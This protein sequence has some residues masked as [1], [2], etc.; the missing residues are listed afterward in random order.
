MSKRPLRIVIVIFC[1]SSSGSLEMERCEHVVDRLESLNLFFLCIHTVTRVP[2]MCSA[3]WGPSGH[4]SYQPLTS[5]KLI[6]RSIASDANK[7]SL[8]SP[9]PIMIGTYSTPRP[10]RQKV[11]H[12][13]SSPL[14]TSRKTCFRIRWSEMAELSAHGVP[15]R[16]EALAPRVRIPHRGRWP[17]SCHVTRSNGAWARRWPSPPSSSTLMFLSL[18][19]QKVATALS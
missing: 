18:L 3:S 9:E 4:C 8:K 7:I 1:D 12:T 5:V 11:R 16:R 19:H 6:R 14:S 2:E 15:V 13:E 10:G 17:H